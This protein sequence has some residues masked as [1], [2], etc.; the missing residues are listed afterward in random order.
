[1][2]LAITAGKPL[3]IL[4]FSFEGFVVYLGILILFCFMLLCYYTSSSVNKVLE[5]YKINIKS[6][7]VVKC[8]V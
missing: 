1:M 2:S 8:H 6:D 4:W 3:N 5:K 7:I